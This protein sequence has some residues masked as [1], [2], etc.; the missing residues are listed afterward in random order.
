MLYL[1]CLDITSLT[2]Y[3]FFNFIIKQMNIILS[4]YNAFVNFIQHLVPIKG[5]ITNVEM[6]RLIEQFKS[7]NTLLKYYNE[8]IS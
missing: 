6:T 5:R 1:I 2:L 7:E 8:L 3:M 4:N